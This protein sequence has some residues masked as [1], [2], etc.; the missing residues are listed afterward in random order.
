MAPRLLFLLG[1]SAVFEVMSGEFI[2]ASGGCES[3]IALLLQGGAQWEKY[4]PQYTQALIQKGSAHFDVISPNENGHLDLAVVSEQLR[5]ATGILIGGGHTPTY[6]QLY[7]LEPIRSMIQERY[8]MGVPIAGM[9]AG[10]LITLKSC[11][12]KLEKIEDQEI[13]IVPGLGLLDDIVIGVHFNKFEPLMRI[14]S[15]MSKTQIQTGLGI[16]ETACAV[17]VNNRFSGIIGKRL[18]IIEMIDYGTQ[19]Y[20]ITKS[21]VKYSASR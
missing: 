21:T 15:A 14:V 4:I 5:N 13:K 18:F 1:G 12:Y 8:Q 16:E 7:A 9:S 10:A 3:R 6:Q 20:S 11:V 19:E 2:S 17:F